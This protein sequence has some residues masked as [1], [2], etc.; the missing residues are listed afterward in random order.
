MFW[1]YLGTKN[2]NFYYEIFK[3]YV[4]PKRNL[5]HSFLVRYYWFGVLIQFF[6]Y[7]DNISKA[8]IFIVFTAGIVLDLILPT[9]GTGL[10]NICFMFWIPNFI[11]TP[12]QLMQKSSNSQQDGTYILF[13][14]NFNQNRNIL[15][16]I[17]N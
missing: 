4:N 11:E 10:K 17:W 5:T 8:K 16:K 14:L 9:T 3:S 1:I 15:S 2:F 6:C 13:F 12:N 7:C